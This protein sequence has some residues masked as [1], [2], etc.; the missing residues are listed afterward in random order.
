MWTGKKLQRLT[1]A[2]I[3]IVRSEC[4]L[5]YLFLALRSGQGQFVRRSAELRG[6]DCIFYLSYS[7]EMELRDEVYVPY[8]NIAVF[9]YFGIFGEG[10]EID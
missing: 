10:A 7:V 2:D 8:M 3:H 4:Q 5:V 1:I 6:T 9:R